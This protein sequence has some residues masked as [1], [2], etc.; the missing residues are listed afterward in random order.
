MSEPIMFSVEIYPSDETRFME[1]DTALRDQVKAFTESLI[2][3][4]TKG[5]TPSVIVNHLNHKIPEP[6][7]V[8][9]LR[10]I[11]GGDPESIEDDRKMARAI[12]RARSMLGMD[13]KAR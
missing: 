5:P 9:L 10:D 3:F 11:V 8:A 13:R 6:A 4:N 1:D 12:E 7:A 2:K